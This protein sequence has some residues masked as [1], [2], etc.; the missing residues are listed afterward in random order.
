VEYAVSERRG[1]RIR[2]ILGFLLETLKNGSEKEL[3]LGKKQKELSFRNVKVDMYL[4]HLNG[5][6]H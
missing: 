5:E 4:R 6:E 3:T 2:I 1:E